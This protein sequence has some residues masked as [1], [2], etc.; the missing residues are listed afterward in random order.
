MQSKGLER[1]RKS[2]HRAILPFLVLMKHVDETSLFEHSPSEPTAI[3]ETS[4]SRL[5]LSTE[6]K[7]KPQPIREWATE[8]AAGE[9]FK[10][11]LVSY[12]ATGSDSISFRSDGEYFLGPNPSIAS[13]TLGA[14]RDFVTKYKP[15]K[16]NGNPVAVMDAKT[17]KSCLISGDMVLMHGATQPSWLHSVPKRKGADVDR[18]RVNTWR[19]ATILAGSENYYR[20][21]V[22]DSGVYR[23][24]VK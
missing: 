10:F 12:C 3:L 6:Y 15:R 24:N 14:Q 18:G 2:T 9:A 4:S 23:W 5:V 17:P 8:V 13:F 1:R 20:D 21:N 7:C 19:W 11:C 16:S 22:G